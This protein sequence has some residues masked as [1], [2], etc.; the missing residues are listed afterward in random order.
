MPAHHIDK[1]R[2]AL[3]GPDRG[4]MADGPEQET[5]DPE[6]QTETERRGQRCR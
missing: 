3:G 1:E 4:G 6:P 2:I 5:R